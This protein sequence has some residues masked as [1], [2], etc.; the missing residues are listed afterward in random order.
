MKAPLNKTLAFGNLKEES[1]LLM[2]F[3]ILA[4]LVTITFFVYD[5]AYAHSG[6]TN[7]SGCHNVTATGGY[8]CHSGGSSGGTSSRSGSGYSRTTLSEADQ[9]LLIFGAVIVIGICWVLI[10]RDSCLLDTQHIANPVQ[11]FL[12]SEQLAPPNSQLLSIL[13]EQE[14]SITVGVVGI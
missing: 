2:K 10:D 9:V 4:I 11:S 3:K 6:R 7:S 5:F 12:L 14:R 1:F 8:H 13:H